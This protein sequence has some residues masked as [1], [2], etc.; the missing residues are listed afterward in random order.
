VQALGIDVGVRKGLDLVV[1]DGRLRPMERYRRVDL[2][3][4]GSRLGEL[5]PDV[6]AI[7]SPP[8]W[9][10]AG[11]SRSTERELRLFGIQSYGTPTEDRGIDHPFYE[12]MRIG[13]EVFRIAAR[14][15]Y[16]RFA[17]GTPRNSAM[18]VFPH[19]SA[20]VL[21]GCLPPRGVRKAAWRA[22]VLRDAGVRGDDLRSPDQVDAALGALTGLVA[23]RGRCTTLGDPREG[24]IALPARVLPPRPYRRCAEPPRR[25]HQQPRLPRTSPCACG[26]PSCDKLTSREFAPGHDAR[27]KSILWRLARAGNDATDE[28]RR[29]RWELPP[30]MR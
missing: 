2:T 24:V 11:R 10:R 1:L 6:V 28:L 5:R 4:L 15:G 22:G 29:R 27:R 13:F 12:W 8:G 9:A 25:D 7:D 30:E 20:V 3:D 14:S 18:E 19:A 21:A 16:R 17:G 23:L 26:D